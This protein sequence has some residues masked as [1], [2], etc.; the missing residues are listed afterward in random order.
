MASELKPKQQQ[1][2]SDQLVGRRR[3]LRE[4]VREELEHG[5]TETH[6]ELAGRV[7]DAEDDALADLLVDA[8]LSEIER[9]V[10][11]LRHI[12]DALQRMSN[13][14]YGVCSDCDNPIDVE[15][16]RAWPTAERC[17]D[18]QELYERTHGGPGHNTL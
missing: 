7:H 11:E 13:G 2:L 1:E 9:H 15:R 6:T 17:I 8:Q 10:Q 18:C 4:M 16:L 12:E 14:T 5:Q 3:E